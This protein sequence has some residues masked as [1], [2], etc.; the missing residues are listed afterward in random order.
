MPDAVST[1][2]VL[3]IVFTLIFAWWFVYTIVVS[4]HWLTFGRSS[5][6]AV[7]ALGTHL[8]ISAWLLFYMTSGLR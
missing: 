6:V 7:P 2:T 5:W 8:F 3:S 1:G 4:F